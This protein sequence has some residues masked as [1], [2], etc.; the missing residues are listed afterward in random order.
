MLKNFK[1]FLINLDYKNLLKKTFFYLRKFLLTIVAYSYTIVKSYKL[2]CYSKLTFDW[3]PMINPY[4]WPFSFFR[5]LTEPYFR[6][7][8]HILPSVKLEGSSVDVSNFVAVE[9]LNLVAFLF[10]NIT[11]Y[12]IAYLDR[13]EFFKNIN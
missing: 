11:L 6:L 9:S 12:S 7:W 8:R 10:I 4:I 1:N 3:F 13:F 2:L 5:L